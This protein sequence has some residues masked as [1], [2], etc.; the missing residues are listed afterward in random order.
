MKRH[1]NWCDKFSCINISVKRFALL[2]GLAFRGG[3]FFYTGTAEPARGIS[4]SILEGVP[5]GG[6]VILKYQNSLWKTTIIKDHYIHNLLENSEL[7]GFERIRFGIVIELDGDSHNE[8]TDYYSQ[9]DNLY[10]IISKMK[11]AYIT[12]PACGHPFLKRRGVFATAL[13]VRKTE[14]ISNRKFDKHL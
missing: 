6:V 9:R 2:L 14:L 10:N 5:A 8:K 4:P 3:V 12:T 13:V 7:T 11:D 1:Y